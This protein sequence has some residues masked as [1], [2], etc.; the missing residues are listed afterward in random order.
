MR[1]VKKARIV[2]F[3]IGLILG[4][5]ILGGVG[6]FMISGRDTKIAELE[7]QKAD[8]LMYVFARDIKADS[9]ILPGD[10]IELETKV[11]NF[12]NG[13]YYGEQNPNT[14]AWS[15]NHYVLSK[16]VEG[17][18][19]PSKLPTSKSDLIGKVVKANVSKNEPVMDSVLYADEDIPAKSERYVEYNFLQ[20]PSD[21]VEN[22]YVDVRIQFPTGEDYIVLVGKKVV[23]ISETNTIF[24]KLNEDEQL[25][26][27]SAIIET[28]MGEGVRL[29]ARKYTDPAT[30]L[31][32]ERIVD[33][34]KLYEDGYEKVREQKRLALQEE[35]PIS[36]DT[37][38]AARSDSSLIEVTDAE[39]AAATGMKLD[40]VKAIREAK[41]N[42]NN[43]IL[44]YFRAYRLQ[45]STKLARTYPLKKEV[46]NLIRTRPNILQEI[47][48]E[49][50]RIAAN[51]TR[52][53]ELERLRADLETA[54]YAASLP[55]GTNTSDVKTKESITQEILTL[56]EKRRKNI[57]ENLEDEQ[58]TQRQERIAYL[59]SLLGT[60][61]NENN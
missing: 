53:D 13:G 10:I 14:G 16:D 31:Y 18:E 12:A 44:N 9:E 24:L 5:A 58:K 57:A 36:G 26:M 8:G 46:L 25:A 49:F 42:D 61:Y 43:D 56:E 54:P 35:Q 33:Y 45:E 6:Y 3:L 19:Y 17:N 34:V 30:Q 21:L 55:Y 4:C 37:E 27:G 20:L 1:Q 7:K 40:F 32:K 28:Y 38:L 41:E 2:F 52:Q 29:Y 50:T 51:N 23:K 60:S 22:E 47:V 11:I 48:D 15:W 59:N 39:V